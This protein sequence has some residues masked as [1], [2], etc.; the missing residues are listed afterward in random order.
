[1]VAVAV[2]V[3]GLAAANHVRA[4]VDF[5]TSS[6]NNNW[7]RHTDLLPRGSATFIVAKGTS[8]EI[9]QLN[10][11]LTTAR[12]YL[13]LQMSSRHATDSAPNTA[14]DLPSGDSA[15]ISL[16]TVLMGS[17]QYPASL[18][19]ADLGSETGNVALDTLGA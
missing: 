17:D 9:L 6:D 16:F 3:S 19:T 8:D 7:V 4:W 14:I 12:R 1:M 15:H 11:R 13:R 10:Y 2:S 18:A 5:Q